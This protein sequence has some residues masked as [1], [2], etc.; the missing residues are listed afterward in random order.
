MEA[1]L[2]GPVERLDT[3]YPLPREALER[4]FGGATHD[5]SGRGRGRRDGVAVRD[6]LPAA[7]QPGDSEVGRYGVELTAERG[8][9][10]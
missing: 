9:Q 4:L 10:R 5:R 2:D 7:V 8:M 6:P 1:A 3:H